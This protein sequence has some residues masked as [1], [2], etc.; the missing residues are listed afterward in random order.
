MA[1]KIPLRLKKEPLLEAV[2]EVRFVS[3]KE[4]VA[5]LL[6][7]LLFKALPEKYPNIVRLPAADI[8]HAIAEKDPAFRYAPKIRLEGDNHSVQIGEHMVSLSNRRP[9]SGWET[10]SSNIRELFGALKDTDL[11]GHL[12]R[13]SLKYVDLIELEV[14]P[15]L[16]LLNVD[17]KLGGRDLC[18]RPVQLRTQIEE[19]D[20]THIIQ[21]AS[22]A[23]VGLQGESQRRR[24]LLIEIDTVRP[25][26]DDE[27][28]D[29]L[30]SCLERAHLA[31]KKMFF[32]L[33]REGTIE[34]LEPVYPE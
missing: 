25:L 18:D 9:Y 4:S 6:P 23:E 29:I 19:A 8:P 22:P 11:A 28:W 10:F 16:H 34:K 27:S 21:V 5:D 24:G 26:K 13:L 1:S 31:S 7:G 33:L 2:C 17:L 3:E 30:E 14:P 20:L 12:Q 15:T 32:E